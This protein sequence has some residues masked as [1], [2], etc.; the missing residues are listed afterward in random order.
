MAA[1]A[2]AAQLHAVGLSELV[3]ASYDQYES[4]AHN[5]GAE[6]DRLRAL[7]ARLSRDRITSPLFDMVAYTRSFEAAL[8]RMANAA[9]IGSAG[10]AT[11]D[12]RSPAGGA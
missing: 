10:A 6:R 8:E 5:L 3:A 7:R 1:R 12:P 9:G 11:D 2:S 4:I